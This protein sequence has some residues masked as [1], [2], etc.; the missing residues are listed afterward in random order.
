V[1]PLVG[2]K[3]DKT[4][5]PLAMCGYNNVFS[6]PSK[7][8][9]DV[10]STYSKYFPT[11]IMPHQGQEYVNK[12]DSYK[13]ATYRNMID[14]GADLVVGAH[15]HAVQSTEVYKGKLIAYSLGNFIFDQ[16]GG[17]T[18]THHAALDVTMD[19]KDPGSEN[20]IKWL[21]LGKNCQKYKDG[22]LSKAQDL[23][24]SKPEFNLKYDIIASENEKRV[25]YKANDKIQEEVLKLTNWA[26]TLKE[27]GQ[28]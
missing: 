13:I 9:L 10:I 26:K 21:E 20:V 17:K 27:L 22:C 11:I 19:F 12:P 8:N 23:K 25:T 6:L 5:I 7:A 16:Q 28:N 2:G 4:L 3:S 24:L 18:V 15:P 1:S 14:N